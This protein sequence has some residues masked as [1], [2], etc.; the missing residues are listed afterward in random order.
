MEFKYI[1]FLKPSFCS[2]MDFVCEN[3][4]IRTWGKST[5]PKQ[6]EFLSI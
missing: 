2:F 1:L 5:A 6:K 4:I 3:E